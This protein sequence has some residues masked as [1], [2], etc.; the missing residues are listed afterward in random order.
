MREKMAGHLIEQQLN[1]NL[2]E[3]QKLH[4]ELSKLTECHD[5]TNKVEKVKNNINKAIKK[6][7]QSTLVDL[8]TK[9]DAYPNKSSDLR[10]Q[11]QLVK[12]EDTKEILT[13]TKKLQEEVKDLNHVFNQLGNIVHVS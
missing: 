12:F 5:Y 11:S 9:V 10:V 1:C 4:D 8:D 13:E 2:V 6:F 7:A 3:L